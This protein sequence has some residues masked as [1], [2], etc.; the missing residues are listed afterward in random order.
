VQ[1]AAVVHGLYRS[2]RAFVAPSRAEG[3]PLTVIE[4]MAHGACIVA[5]DIPPHRELLGDAGVLVPVGD[6]AALAEALRWVS[7][8]AAAARA[9]GLR[10]QARLAASDEY[11]WDGVAARTA[12]VLASL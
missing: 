3:N 10:A 9:I 2:A 5:S 11:Q 6:A 1:P 12:E 7:T 4:A 8:D